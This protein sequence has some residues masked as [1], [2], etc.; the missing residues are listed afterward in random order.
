MA[1]DGKSLSERLSGLSPDQLRALLRKGR[2]Q[3]SPGVGKPPK[4]ERNSTGIYPLSKA[5]ERMW[6]LHNLSEGMA[7]YNNPVALRITAEVPLNIG[8]LSQSLAL[9][10]ERH[11]ILRTTFMVVDGQ[12]VQQVH[13]QGVPEILYEDF[14]SFPLTERE[15]KAMEVAVRHG[16]TPVP[17]DRLPL[18]RFKVLHLR[19]LEY[20]LL[21]NPHHIISDG[22]SNAQFAREISMTYA[23]LESN[24]TPRFP[25][26]EYQYVDFVQWERTWMGGTGYNEQLDF[27]KTQLR[28]LPEPLNLPV[29]FQRPAIMSHRGNKEVNFLD[30]AE[31]DKLRQFCQKENLTLFHLL[32]GCFGLLMSKYT[33]QNDIMIGVPVARRNQ[34]SFQQTLGLF[35]NTL[36][37]RIKTSSISSAA[38]FL[39]DVKKYCQQA[40]LRQELPFEKLIEEV[41]PDRNLS[42]NPVFQVHF[43]YQNIPSL[44]KVSGLAVKPESIDYSFSKFDLNFWVEEANEGL[45]LSIT[46]PSDIFLPRTVQKMLINYKILLSSVI[47]HPGMLCGKLAYYPE[48]ERSV[49]IGKSQTYPEPGAALHAAW[50]DEFKARAAENPGFAAVRDIRQQLSYRDLDLFSDLLATNLT[51]LGV[52]RNDLVGLLLPRDASLIIS[53]LG[54]FKSGAAYVP[55]DAGVPPERL[56]FI[57]ADASLKFII[58]TGDLLPVAEDAGITLLPYNRMVLTAEDADTTARA[59]GPLNTFPGPGELAYVIYT[60]G[61]TGKPKG[62]CVGME[63]LL[64]Y[65]KAVWQRMKLSPGDSFATISSIAADLGNTM[66]F[67][68]LVHGGEVVIIPEEHC[69]DASL[70]AQWLENRTVDCLKIVPSHLAGLLHSS[71]ADKLLPKKLLVLGGETCSLEIVE[72]V[73]KISPGLRIMNHYGPTEATIGSLTWEVPFQMAPG[74]VTSPIGYPLDNTAVYIADA[75]LQPLPKG[76]PGEII[77]SGKN[78]TQ[79][80]LNQPGLTEEKFGTDPLRKGARIYRTGDLGRMDEEGA[81]AFLGRRDHQVKIRGFRVET[82]EIEHAL[83]SFHAVEQSVV[84]LP[85]NISSVGSVQAAITLKDD[86]DFDEHVLRNWLAR[87]LPSYMIPSEIHVV[88]RFP[89]TS[90]G[91]T[92]L[93]ELNL[94]IMNREIGKTAAPPRDLIELRLVNIFRKVLD[95]ES[96]GIGDGF[97]ELGGH[98]LLAIQLFA[99][100]EMEFD[101]HLPLATLFE[102]DNVMK[103]AELLRGSGGKQKISSLVS[104][105]PGNDK[106]LVYL[107]HPAGGNVLCYYELA[108]ELGSDYSVYGL[109]A[110][111]LTGKSV[112][113]VSDMARLYLDEITLPDSKE[114]VVFAGWSMG[115]LVAF[116]MARQVAERFGENPRLMIIDQVAPVARSVSMINTLVDPVARMLTFAGKVAHLVGRPLGIAGDDLAGKSTL[117]QS[118]V[119]LKAFKA[120]NLVP[121]DMMISDFH[122]YLGLMI[123]HN[124]ITSVCT[125]GTFDG[126]SLLVRAEDSLPPLDNEDKAPVRT[127]D[128]DWGRWIMKDLTIVN[129]P[130]NHV[131]LIAPPFVRSLALSLMHWISSGR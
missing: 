45:I 123:H 95:T 91:K 85:A 125:A 111:G 87:R 78:I 5:Q 64:N 104:I 107:V 116:E 26:P 82:R 93:K 130:G 88:S 121:P 70:L 90:N 34:L 31:T 102:R 42:T 21:I 61:T 113:T 109:Q 7:L 9:L 55:L 114:N 76:I 18:M 25:V 33:G 12:P 126:K 36:P 39:E 73:R 58:S 53:I 24:Q 27:W 96:V 100:I 3:S 62:V 14:R 120:V 127:A 30:A 46:Y 74:M 101:I 32:F 79:G 38:S 118:G 17:L 86:A 98:S 41:N 71:R 115:A 6:F 65:S 11:E 131:S 59:P 56:R 129:L 103:L 1:T 57:A 108:R 83:N 20:I 119:F 16:K 68:P 89:L 124:E 44:Y 37:L 106:I 128:L 122:G 10:I 81:V 92:D 72:Q 35:I 40:F 69:T 80:Y 47:S 75:E 112:D 49:S 84:L 60:S 13:P 52:A 77:L 19:D 22:W 117:D 110:T 29:D 8:L 67:P 51:R 43:V 28:D 94:M 63:Q 66:I 23:A 4:M 50:M 54:I 15:L 48:N 99:A 105:R 2:D 97:F